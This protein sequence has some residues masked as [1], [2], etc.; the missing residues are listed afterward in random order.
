LTASII[1]GEREGGGSKV[2]ELDVN[3]LAGSERPRL[4]AADFF[5]ENM[6]G[7]GEEIQCGTRGKRGHFIGRPSQSDKGRSGSVA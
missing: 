4:S 6:G 2:T 1:S 7:A 3:P 5:L